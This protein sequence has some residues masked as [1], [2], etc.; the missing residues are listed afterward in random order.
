MQYSLLV[1]EILFYNPCNITSV[2]YKEVGG[3]E[4]DRGDGGGWLSQRW[5]LPT[6]R[7]QTV[8]MCSQ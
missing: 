5:V 1:L 6:I 4:E 8:V 3:W 2:M 7:A